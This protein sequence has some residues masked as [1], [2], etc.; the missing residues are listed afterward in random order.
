MPKFFNPGEV[1]AISVRVNTEGPAVVHMTVDMADGAVKFYVHRGLAVLYELDTTFNSSRGTSFG[2]L[3]VAGHT[4]IS[5]MEWWVQSGDGAITAVLED[6]A[7]TTKNVDLNPASVESLDSWSLDRVLRSVAVQEPGFRLMAVGA[8]QGSPTPTA[9]AAASTASGGSG[10]QADPD[11]PDLSPVQYGTG[12]TGKPL[13]YWPMEATVPGSPRRMTDVGLIQELQ[14]VTRD[15]PDCPLYPIVTGVPGGGKSVLFRAA[16]GAGV[17]SSSFT[18]QHEAYMV[19]GKS[20]YGTD[21]QGKFFERFVMDAFSRAYT[22]IHDSSCPDPCGKSVFVGEEW[23]M[24]PPTLGTLL[25][26]AFDGTGSITYEGKTFIQS[27]DFFFGAT[28]NEDAVGGFVADAMW[29]R[30]SVAIER[31]P[32]YKAAERLGVRH[33]LVDLARGLL[34]VRRSTSPDLMVPSIRTLKQADLMWRTFGEAAGWGHL[35]NQVSHKP[36]QE[37]WL[38][39][40]QMVCGSEAWEHL[41]KTGYEPGRLVMSD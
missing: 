16:C 26:P 11:A 24:I 37:E 30:I 27:P 7:G 38:R 12:P 22:H 23:N 14:R 28:M 20:E 25:H 6:S 1:S 8:A 15:N 3:L 10:G 13:T 17:E 2:Q 18:D 31:E 19:L 33:E 34:A 35:V 9:T 5:S 4:Q 32:S 41:T 40:I 29:S 36:A 21:P 39:K